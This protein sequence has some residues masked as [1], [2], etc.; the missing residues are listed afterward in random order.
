MALNNCFNSP[1]CT[2]MTEHLGGIGSPAEAFSLVPEAFVIKLAPQSPTTVTA[3]QYDHPTRYRP[4][5]ASSRSFPLPSNLL[6]PE[7]FHHHQNHFSLVIK[8]LK[9]RPMRW[10]SHL[11]GDA[12]PELQLPGGTER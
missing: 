7:L 5:S 11:E 3:H 6:L 2:S 8:Q 10:F 4:D 9:P 12:Q 1:T